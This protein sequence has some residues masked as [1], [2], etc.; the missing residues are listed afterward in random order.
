[1]EELRGSEHHGRDTDIGEFGGERVARGVGAAHAREDHGAVRGEAGQRTERV[2]LVPE[3]RG[4][5]P[6]RLGLPGDLSG[7]RVRKLS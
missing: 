2:Q 3:A 4:G 6:E 5:S 7:E 1:M